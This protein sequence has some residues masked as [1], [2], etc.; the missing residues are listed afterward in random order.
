MSAAPESPFTTDIPCPGC[1]YNLKGTRGEVCPE[2]GIRVGPWLL[3][4]PIENYKS[5]RFRATQAAAGAASILGIG[6]LLFETRR[7]RSH[8][9]TAEVL[10]LILAGGGSLL[11]CLLWFIYARRLA[12]SK[13]ALQGRVATV[14]W[15]FLAIFLL[16]AMGVR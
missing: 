3:N 9:T 15:M 14:M 2:C 5:R 8:H 7:I 12:R 11:M 10:Q 6:A 1:R 13:P 16:A 4:P